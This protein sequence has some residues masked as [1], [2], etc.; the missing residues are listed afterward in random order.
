[1]STIQTKTK[2]G[3][4]VTLKPKHYGVDFEAGGVSGSIYAWDEKA[5][6]AKGLGPYSRPVL[7]TISREDYDA[8]MAAH[9][10]LKAEKDAELAATPSPGRGTDNDILDKLPTERTRLRPSRSPD[11]MSGLSEQQAVDAMLG[12]PVYDDPSYGPKSQKPDV[13][14]AADVA[15]LRQD[16]TKPALEEKP[17]SAYQTVDGVDLPGVPGKIVVARKPDGTIVQVGK[18]ALEDEGY[19]ALEKDLKDKL[20]TLRILHRTHPDAL[21]SIEDGE[22]VDDTGT[23]PKT[24]LH[25]QKAF[26]P[27]RL[28]RGGH[29]EKSQRL[30]K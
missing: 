17:M 2:G 28:A 18:S 21:W 30:A 26:Y 25:I 23:G 14:P 22:W 12:E 24:G 15:T 7:L 20:A 10:Q 1:M 6:G 8:A 13:V 5:G 11:P 9:G 4:Q 16:E 19:G 3:A 27:W 29:T